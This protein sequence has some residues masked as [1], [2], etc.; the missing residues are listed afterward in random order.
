MSRR[1]L[2]FGW[3]PHTTGEPHGYRDADRAEAQR[4]RPGPPCSRDGCSRSQSK[5]NTHC[6]QVCQLLD[7]EFARLESVCRQAGPGSRST[8]AWTAL[9]GIA[10]AWSEY[11][12]VRGILNHVADRAQS[13]SEGDHPRHHDRGV[14]R[15]H[16]QRGCS[17]LGRNIVAGDARKCAVMSSRSSEDRRGNSS[18]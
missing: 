15:R 9:V 6:T 16:Q 13:P 11:V 7:H 3:T 18:S 10:D 2:V 14:R 5:G 12:K 8:E 17:S 4:R 1:L